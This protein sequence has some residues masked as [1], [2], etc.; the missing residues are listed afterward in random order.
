MNSPLGARFHLTYAK[1]ALLKMLAVAFAITCIKINCHFILL[2]L[3]ML[4]E[5]NLTKMLPKLTPWIYHD[6]TSK[7]VKLI[8]SQK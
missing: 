2:S 1:S 6:G 3:L 5:N 4:A 7:T 8:Y